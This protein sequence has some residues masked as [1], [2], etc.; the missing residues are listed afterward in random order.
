[1]GSRFVEVTFRFRDQL[2]QGMDAAS[3]KVHGVSDKL[4]TQSRR[5]SM[6]GSE[7]KKCGRNITR[8][9]DAMTKRVTVPIVAAAAASSKLYADFDKAMA[10]VNTLLDDDSHLEAYKNAVLGV[11]DELGIESKTLA[12]GL[13]QTIS[14]LG[15]HGETTAKTFE[16]MARSAKAGGAETVDAVNMIATAMNGYGEVS[17]ETAQRISDL[18][19]KTVKLG[20]TTFPEL[21]NNMSPLFP[22]AHTLGLSY[23][24]LYATMST[25]TTSFAGNTAEASTQIKGLMTGF[26]KPSKAMVELMDEL[27]YSS[28]ADMVKS[29]GLAGALKE[30]QKVAGEDDMAKYFGN[31]RGLTAAL[32]LSGSGMKKYEKHLKEMQGATGATGDA[33]KKVANTDA[34]KWHKALVKLQNAGIKFGSVV[35]PAVTPLIEKLGTAISKAAKWFDGLSE[36]QQQTIVKTLAI[37]AATGPVL[38]IVG[39][40]VTGIG[41]LI[42]TVGKFGKALNATGTVGGALVKVFP[43]AGRAITLFGKAFALVGKLMLAH[44]IIAIIAAIAIGAVL[45][46]KNWDKIRPHLQPV[47]DMINKAKEIFLNFKAAASE[48]LGAVIEKFGELK[49]RAGN[50]FK[51]A[52]SA[53]GDF[54]SKCQN[55]TS[56]IMGYFGGI[57]NFVKGVFT[58]NWKAALKGIVQMYASIFN[59]IKDIALAV[60]RAIGADKAFAKFAKTA[61]S[62]LNAVKHKFQELKEK[63]ANLKEGVASKFDAMKNKINSF[64]EGFTSAIRKVVSTILDFVNNCQNSTSGIMG[65][66]GGLINFIKGVFTGNWKAAW[67]G[68][69]QAFTSIFNGIKNVARRAISGITSFINPILTKIEN[70]ASKLGGLASKAGSAARAVNSIPKN[71]KGTNDFKGGL[72]YINEKGG[73]IVNLPQHTQIIPHD[74]SMEATRAAGRAAAARSITIAKLAD[75]LIVREEADIDR[76]AERLSEKLEMLEGDMVYD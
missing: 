52:G 15:D 31:I 65:Y 17:D 56:G 54:V 14:V 32:G 27:G 43:V 45:I 42:G 49:E 19:F 72:T 44:P 4:A 59:G 48:K 5:I 64:R 33:L 69:V 23:E 57:I 11:S 29:L 9:G 34:E 21:A 1:M 38:S 16:I 47:F 35:L 70:V 7:W 68:V 26:L 51:N 55:S 76:I 50:A 73:E 62:K 39:R 8:V 6:L 12:E 2:T 28:G 3:K 36:S 22:L 74:V 53:A 60:F 20:K 75:T 66:Y 13:Y 63:A 18:S 25:A 37:A 58:G 24:E 40:G 61:V 67:R 71:A 10:Q 41:G 46:W 30:V